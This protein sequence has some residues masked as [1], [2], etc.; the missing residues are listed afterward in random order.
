VEQIGEVYERLA[1]LEAVFGE[2]E[3]AV[4][5]NSDDVGRLWAAHWREIK[6]QRDEVRVAAARLDMPLVKCC[7]CVCHP[8]EM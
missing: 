4:K 1:A 3:T 5:Y 7:D 6:V 8:P 2:L